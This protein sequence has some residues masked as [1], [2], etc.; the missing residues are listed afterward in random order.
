MLFVFKLLHGCVKC[1]LLDY[2]N[3]STCVHNTKGNLFKQNKS[4]AKLIMRQ[5]HFV[6]RFI[7][8][9]NSLSNNI[10]CA[11][12]CSVF[13]RQLLTYTNFNLRG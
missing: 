12:T 13:K 4:H 9:L 3:V 7:N 2:F 10:V 5:N 6:I 1:N 11:S 8:N